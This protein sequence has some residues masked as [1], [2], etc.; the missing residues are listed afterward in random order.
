MPTMLARALRSRGLRG[1]APGGVLTTHVAASTVARSTRIARARSSTSD[2]TSA[3]R[4]RTTSSNVDRAASAAAAHAER[5][6]GLRRLRTL[7]ISGPSGAGT[8]GTSRAA[9]S[10]NTAS[11]PADQTATTSLRARRPRSSVTSSRPVTPSRSSR[12]TS[13]RTRGR[14]WARFVRPQIRTIS[15]TT[16]GSTSA[17]APS[18]ASDSGSTGSSDPG[19]TERRG[20]PGA[21]STIGRTIEP[22]SVFTL[23][24]RCVD[25]G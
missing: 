11:P 25:R 21:D 14:A 24:Q 2:S 10:R 23:D 22:P 5:S 20:R 6:C 8:P 1:S 7:P 17:S 9:P 19:R 12:C 18:S 4:A 13:A 15:R 3:P 16:A